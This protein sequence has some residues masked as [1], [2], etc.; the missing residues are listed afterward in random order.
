M[1]V[2][3]R[4]IVTAI[5]FSLI[6][7]GIYSVYWAIMLAR[8]SV[9]V[10]DEKD[11]GILEIILM[12]FLPFIGFYL[13]EKKLAEGCAEKGIAHKDNSVIYLVLGLIGFSIVNFCMMQSDLN[14][15]AE[16]AE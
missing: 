3:S 2:K 8:E 5:I 15:I 10:K 4:N 1:K 11:D 12:L 16:A 6:T 13:A 14:K 9:S 7:C